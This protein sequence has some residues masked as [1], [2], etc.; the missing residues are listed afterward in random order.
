[1]SIAER[2]DAETLWEVYSS[3]RSR[4]LRD[5]LVVFYSP[6]VK[7]VAGRLASGLPSH[8][9]IADLVS[10]GMFGLMQAIERFEPSRGLKFETFAISRIRGSILDE[11]RSSDWV[12]RSVRNMSKRVEE[13]YSALESR[14]G[15]TPSDSE[16]AGEM[17]ITEDELMKVF[18][19]I[20]YTSVV[21][22]EQ[23]LPGLELGS[24]L[25]FSSGGESGTPQPGAVLEQKESRQM[26]RQAITALAEREKTVLALY[27][28]ENLT[29]A[30]IGAV[31][32]V[33]EGRVCQIHTK[34][35]LQLKVKLSRSD[36]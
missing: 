33:T 28:Y 7:Y 12:P 16:V 26:V 31:L 1:M 2:T 27:Y 30:E 35:V 6:L 36:W 19:R 5:E 32:G 20:S 25:S 13:A 24:S 23:V 22:L 15:R 14:F 21:A 29:M 17:G 3:K 9:E 18:S 11:L 8:V 4:E 10:Y 34:A